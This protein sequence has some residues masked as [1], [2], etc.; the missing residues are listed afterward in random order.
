MSSRSFAQRCWDEER[1][2][3]DAECEAASL[4]YEDGWTYKELQMTFQIGP[5]AIRKVLDR[6]LDR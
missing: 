5:A 1:T 4:L 6:E 3:T 2:L